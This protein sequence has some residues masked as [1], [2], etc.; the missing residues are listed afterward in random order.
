M[1]GATGTSVGVAG[2]VGTG[3]GGAIVGTAGAGG[4]SV[5]STCIQAQVDYGGL[6]DK[7]A[8]VYETFGCNVDSDCV[9]VFEPGNCGPVCPDISLAGSVASEF[10]GNLMN[11]AAICTGACPPRPPVFCPANPSVCVGGRC[12]LGGITGAGGAFGGTGS[13]GANGGTGGVPG[14]GPCMIPQCKPGY[15]AEVDPSISCCPICR[16]NNCNLAPCAKPI[17]PAGTHAEVPT[18]QCCP[19]CV[20]GFSQDCNTAESQYSTQRQAYLEKYGSTP[21]KQDT[22]CRL[23]FEQNSCVSN[24][25]EA[26]PVSTAGLFESNIASL[27]MACNAACPPIPSPP[28]VPQVAVCSNGSCTTVPAGSFGLQ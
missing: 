14:C 5:S 26:L 20:N 11:E 22:D 19:V 3:S 21:C 2:G 6:R 13:A 25:G 16:P 24:C 7:L 27:A 28:C 12:E 8:M 17:C 9:T 23:V 18:G 1:A 4:S 10:V 15:M